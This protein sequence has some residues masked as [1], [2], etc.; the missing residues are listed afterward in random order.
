MYKIAAAPTQIMT[1]SGI[2][3]STEIVSTILFLHQLTPKIIALAACAVKL[4]LQ[5]PHP[6]Q[7]AD[8]PPL[9]V[10]NVRGSL[11]RGLTPVFF[12]KLA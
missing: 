5:M 9:D 8:K 1:T 12:R 2:I 11:Q 7:R 6:V 4:L 3:N 10:L